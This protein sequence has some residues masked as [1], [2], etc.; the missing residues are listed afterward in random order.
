VVAV[1]EDP[2]APGEGLVP[3]AGQAD[4]QALHAARQRG[5]IVGLDDEV[6][7]VALEGVVQDAE[8]G[9]A[10]VVTRAG[11]GALQDLAAGVGAQPGQGVDGAQADVVDGGPREARSPAA[12]DR[13]AVLQGRAAA[14]APPRPSRWRGDAAHEVV[15]ADLGPGRHGAAASVAAGASGGR[16]I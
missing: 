7:V 16:N 8:A 2:A 13:V 10:G 9:D 4:R 15:E 12:L 14:P 3:A 5:V 11:Q 1:G 6:E